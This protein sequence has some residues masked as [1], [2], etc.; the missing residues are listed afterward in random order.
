M[1]CDYG[2]NGP[3]PSDCANSCDQGKYRAE[4]SVNSFLC[5]PYRTVKIADTKISQIYYYAFSDEKDLGT[6]SGTS[7]S[8]K[9]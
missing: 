7:N 8:I 4:T 6:L 1:L 9:L 3:L 2:A 5:V